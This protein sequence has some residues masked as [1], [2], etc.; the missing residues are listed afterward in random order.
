MNI[1][2]QGVSLQTLAP[3]IFVLV[4]QSF[5]RNKCPLNHGTTAM[6]LEATVTFETLVTIYRIKGVSTEGG[7]NNTLRC[8]NL[9]S[10]NYVAHR[11]VTCERM[12]ADH[13]KMA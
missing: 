12:R 11:C 2:Y 13:L 8:E 10:Y 6:K 7:S 1:T 5:E 4:Y 3:F 9:K